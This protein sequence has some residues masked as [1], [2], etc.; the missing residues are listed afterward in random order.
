MA[1]IARAGSLVG[2]TKT[3]TLTLAAELHKRGC[4]VTVVGTGSPGDSDGPSFESVSIRPSRSNFEYHRQL[5]AWVRRHR[6]GDSAVI[7]AQRPDFL[8]PF[9]RWASGSAPVCTLHGDPLVG[10]RLHRPLASRGYEILERK[11]LLAARRVISVGESSRRN[12]VAR[13]PFVSPKI[14]VIPVGV[15]TALFRPLD[16]NWAR[17]KMEIPEGP[18]LLYAGRLEPE[19]RVDVLLDA[20]AMMDHPPLV[21]IAGTGSRERLLRGKARGLP[22]RFLGAVPHAELAFA[23]AASDAI[24]LPSA[25]EG[26]PTV[27][28]EALACGIP[29]IATPVGDLPFLIKP[30]R[31][32]YLFDGSAKSLSKVLEGHLSDFRNLQQECINTGRLFSWDRIAGDVLEVLRAAAD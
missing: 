12:Y 30:G 3:Y 11:A 32:G 9:L 24:V 26:T 27:A 16:R 31:N 20:V 17:A 14:S 13:Y 29:V 15:S 2:G 25:L 28:I 21:L 6:F 10:M 1:P 22:V 8:I 7:D 18:V 23:M 5:R 19:K 4:A